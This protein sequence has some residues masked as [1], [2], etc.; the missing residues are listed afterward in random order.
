MAHR[1]HRSIGLAALISILTATTAFAGPP[2]ICFPFEIGGARTLPMG[3]G[4][5]KATDP[6]YDVSRLVSDTTALLTPD[7]PV[8]VRMETIRR[9]VI[10]A[11]GRGDVA[12]ALLDAVA[13]RAKAPNASALARFDW[14]YM[15]ETYRQARFMTADR[16]PALDG[17]DG[18]KLV[19]AALDQQKDPAIELAAALIVSDRPASAEYR[20]H[21]Q[22]V[23]AA[24]PSGSLL[25]RNL[26]SHVER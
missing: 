8:L 14:G 26:K 20:A 25:A 16:L 10:Y 15:V 22:H 11:A 23:S 5:W 24:A 6:A 2:L 1:S 17:I 19:L 21:V 12:R 3:S 7:A 18:Y 9:A 13:A 4:S